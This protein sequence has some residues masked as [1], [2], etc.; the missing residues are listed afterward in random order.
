[1]PM[2]KVIHRDENMTQP[3]L[4]KVFELLIER[5]VEKLNLPQQDRQQVLD[6]KEDI[7][8]ELSLGLKDKGIKLEDFGKTDFLKKMALTLITAILVGKN[9]KL[10]D[11]LDK[12]KPEKGKEL[13]PDDL[14]KLLS[15]EDLKEL[16]Q[17]F[18]KC[19]NEIKM[20]LKPFQKKTKDGKEE[21]KTPKKEK[22]SVEPQEDE[23]LKNL[24][25]NLCGLLSK[26][27]TIAAV[28]SYFGGNPG[29]E[30]QN[31][32]GTYAQIDQLN[33]VDPSNPGELETSAEINYEQFG[34]Q[35]DDLKTEEFDDDALASTLE[36]PN[37]D[38]ASEME[39]VLRFLPETP[40]MK[41]PG[42]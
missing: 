5:L 8:K 11:G 12:L 7:A 3:Q 20:C 36:V 37:K 32:Q 23:N 41:P 14:K 18:Q 40:T 42:S 39:D 4:Q 25:I 19:K 28:V 21:E 22:Q 30:D 10:M 31:P 29:I 17:E 35:F 34:I 6:K 38:I 27:S 15:D 24:F 26:N 33:R 2:P 9:D 16:Q 13:K 1:M